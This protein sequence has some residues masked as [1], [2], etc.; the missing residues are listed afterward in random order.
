MYEIIASSNFV[1]C[2]V[3]TSPALV[4]KELNIPVVYLHVGDVSIFEPPVDNEIEVL[5][6]LEEL[7]LY[8]QRIMK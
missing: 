3:G 7:L 2:M 8:Y 6:S 1:I 4:A 5:N